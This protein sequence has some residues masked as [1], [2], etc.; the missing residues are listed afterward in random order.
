VVLYLLSLPDSVHTQRANI[1]IQVSL[2]GQ[3]GLVYLALA[4]AVGRGDL[5]RIGLL[6]LPMMLGT[7]VGSHLFHRVPT[8]V[9]RV[10]VMWTLIVVSACILVL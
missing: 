8:A 3:V 5:I 2:L 10:V 1:V 9:F 6:T 7:W 4:G